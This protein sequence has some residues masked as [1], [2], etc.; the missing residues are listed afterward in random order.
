MHIP[1]GFLT[2][3]VCAA[4]TAVAVAGLAAATVSAVRAP[5]IA[6]ALKVAAVAGGI[7]AAQMVNFPVAQGTSGHLIG[8]ALATALLGPS[9]AILVV[10]L[11]LV[12]QCGMFGDGGIYALGANITNMA[13]VG[14]GVSQAVL[15]MGR[16]LQ[17]NVPLAAAIAACVSVMVA[18]VACAV[19]LAASGV[20]PLVV[21]LP[22]M[23]KIHLLIG[24]GE[25]MIT[26]AVVAIALSPK[27]SQA[28]RAAW[29]GI[30]AGLLVAAVVS[31]WASASPDGLE[32]VAEQL[33]FAE[34]AI[35][36]FTA[37]LPEYSTPHITTEGLSTAI[38]GIVGTLLVIAAAVLFMQ[39]KNLF[40]KPAL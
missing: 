1:D 39:S 36:T 6:P 13:M 37:P 2:D 19:E 35:T 40:Q 30:A 29:I 32:A 9:L 22:A 23:L 15:W 11:V 5:K 34:Q 27:V 38:A 12:V 24:T 33:G 31:P 26:A 8:A 4:T 18:A 21:V 3:P 7:F 17:L 10:A 14:V 16:K 25:A 20:Q 28:P